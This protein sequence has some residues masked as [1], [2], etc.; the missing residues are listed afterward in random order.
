MRHGPICGS[1]SFAP[2]PVTG[3]P[4]RNCEMERQRPAGECGVEGHLFEPRDPLTWV[5]WVSRPG[6]LLAAGYTI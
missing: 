3:E 5:A 4:A 2:N 6:P 1:L